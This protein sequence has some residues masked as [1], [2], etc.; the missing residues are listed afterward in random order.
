[1]VSVSRVKGL[2][3]LLWLAM[4]AAP[5]APV[6]AEQAGAVLRV[7]VE[8]LEQQ[9]PKVY[10][11]VYADEDTW[12]GEEPAA[13]AAIDPATGVYVAAI[14]LQ[15]GRYAFTAYL[16]SNGNGE[17]DSN[18]IGI[19]K[20]PVALSNGARPRFGPPKFDDAAFSLEAAGATQ[21]IRMK[22]P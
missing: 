11:S 2:A 15:P 20:E 16:D 21:V 10:V 1:M 22:K 8:G 13:T 9:S 7:Q 12:L 3:G 14:S 6:C 4:V 18:F 17:L 5:G 19:P